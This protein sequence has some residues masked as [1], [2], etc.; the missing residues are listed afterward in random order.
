MEPETWN[1]VLNANLTAMYNVT[2]PAAT[3]MRA[4]GAGAIVNIASNVI[5][6]GGASGPAYAA[7]RR[8]CWASPGPWAAT[9]LPWAFG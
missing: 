8:G 6:T 9:W 5:G 7:A 1:R 3:V 4:K 2:K